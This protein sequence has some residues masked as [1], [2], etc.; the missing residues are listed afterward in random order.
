MRRAV[1]AVALGV[2]ALLAVA[3]S[4]GGSSPG[5]AALGSTTTTSPAGGASGASSQ[6]AY[7]DA[8]KYAQCMRTHG[9]PNMPD[10]DAQGDFLND[11]GKLNGVELNPN[12][13]AF[14]TANKECQHLLPNGGKITQAELQ[15]AMAGALKHSACMRSH[16]VTNFPD[17]VVEGGGISVTL[18]GI[19]PNSAVFKAAQKACQ[20]T[21]PFGP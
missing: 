12:T 20:K 19:D 1:I 6:L 3:C 7:S 16:G 8:V 21:M 2:M 15:R 4:S 9:V 17:P 11:R 13:A 18:R 14:N 5:V 10:P